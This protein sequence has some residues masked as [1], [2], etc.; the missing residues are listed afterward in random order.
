MTYSRT[1]WNQ[2]AIVEALRAAG[3]SVFITS[4]V[5]HGFPDLVVGFD[6]GNEKRTYLLE[7]KAPDAK[8]TDDELLFMR[9]WCGDYHVVRSPEEAVRIIGR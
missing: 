1:D 7:V 3:A 8:L 9:K 6:N 2:S 4:G 5:R